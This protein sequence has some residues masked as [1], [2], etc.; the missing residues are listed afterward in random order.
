MQHIIGIVETDRLARSDMQKPRLELMAFHDHHH[1]FICGN[2][3]TVQH[4]GEG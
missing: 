1:R 3:W 4:C 2:G